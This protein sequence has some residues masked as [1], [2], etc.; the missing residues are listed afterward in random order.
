[1]VNILVHLVRHA[2]HE[3]LGHVLSG[4]SEIALS[5]QGRAT[6]Q[7]LARHWKAA[8]PVA[9]HS[10]PRRRA[11]ETAEPTAMLCALPVQLDEE[12]NEV[13]FGEWTGCSFDQLDTDPAWKFWNSARSRAIP[14]K[15]E[16]MTTAASRA[17]R[18]IEALAGPAAG[19]LL[20]VSHADIIR[21][22]IAHY[23]GL[24]FDRIGAF[25]VDP[26][27]ASKLLI[28]ADGGRLISLNEHVS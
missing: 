4:R 22:V 11:R 14:P 12:L 20:I 1:V 2:H 24:S 7:S 6:A 10:S 21:G 18:H 19:P 9:I 27:S 5:P 26:G 17:V 3:E 13:D 16:S 28:G 15:G 8:R 23:L 25:D